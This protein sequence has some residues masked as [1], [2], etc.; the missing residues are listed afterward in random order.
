MVRTVGRRRSALC[1]R[2]CW[3]A[4]KLA[5]EAGFHRTDISQVGHR[6]NWIGAVK[7]GPMACALGGSPNPVQ[8]QTEGA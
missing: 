2:E 3:P 1:Q 4:G 5:L 8:G 6:D 7:A